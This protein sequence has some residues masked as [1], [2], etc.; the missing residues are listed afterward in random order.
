MGKKMVYSFPIIMPQVRVLQS[1]RATHIVVNAVVYGVV[2]NFSIRIS[3]CNL[4]VD[5]S[6]GV[7]AQLISK[8]D[9]A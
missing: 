9:K 1:L 4:L 6:I 3:I 2:D 7:S 8:V 5:S